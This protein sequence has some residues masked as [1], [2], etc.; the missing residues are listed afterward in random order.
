MTNTLSI[1]NYQNNQIRTEIINNEPYFCGVD[2]CNALSI[3]N[4]RD[5]IARLHD[6]VVITDVIDKL[7]RKQSVSYINE[8]NLYKVAF[9]SRKPRAESFVNWVCK[10]VL[11]SI[12]KTGTYVAPG[13]VEVSSYTRRLPSA[14][15]EIVLSEKARSEIGGIVKKCCAVAIKDALKELVSVLDKNAPKIS[16]FDER[17]EPAEREAYNAIL[18]YGKHMKDK[19][20]T[21]GVLE[22]KDYILSGRYEK[23]RKKWEKIDF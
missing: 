13:A 6:G 5:T 3:K 8:P 22:T 20:M 7:G 23:E 4:N 17:F 11:P 18:A 15:R 2:V 10:E 14:P 1:F 16:V 9:Q 21:I 12:R 19:G